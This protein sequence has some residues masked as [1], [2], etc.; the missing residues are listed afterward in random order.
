MT[1]EIWRGLRGW[2]SYRDSIGN[3]GRQ[4]DPRG[5]ARRLPGVDAQVSSWRDSVAQRDGGDRYR[6]Q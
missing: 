2:E 3:A 4:P 5:E 6:V 1:E